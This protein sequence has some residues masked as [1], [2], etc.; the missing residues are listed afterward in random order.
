MKIFGKLV[1]VSGNKITL[2]LDDDA[3]ELAHFQ[4]ELFLS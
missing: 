4:M 2:E 1:Q 3:N